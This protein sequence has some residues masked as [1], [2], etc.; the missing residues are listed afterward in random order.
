MLKLAFSLVSLG[1]RPVTFLLSLLI[2]IGC[3]SSKPDLSNIGTLRTHIRDDGTKLF[4]FTSQRPRR[5]PK[6]AGE[7]TKGSAEKT[8]RGQSQRPSQR[9]PQ[10]KSR[11]PQQTDRTSRRQNNGGRVNNGFREHLLKALDERLEQT[12]YCR[13]GY[14]PLGNYIEFGQFEIRGECQETA[15]KQDRVLFPGGPVP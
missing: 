11:Q 13:E 3:S 2:I 12:G 8:G 14:L 1:F 4:V 10:Q 9:P 7:N 5:T 15:T 6:Q